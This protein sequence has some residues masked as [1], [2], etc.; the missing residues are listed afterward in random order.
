MPAPRAITVP[1]M[2]NRFNFLDIFSSPLWYYIL[3]YQR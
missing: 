2:I 3:F 1:V